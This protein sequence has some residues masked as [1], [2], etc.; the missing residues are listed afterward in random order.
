MATA[1][2][3]IALMPKAQTGLRPMAPSPLPLLPVVPLVLLPPGTAVGTKGGSV[4]E[5]WDKSV[6]VPVGIWTSKG[7]SGSTVESGLP[8]GVAV[9]AT[10]LS[11]AP[12]ASQ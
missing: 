7:E 4:A 12:D 1:M 5:N 10:D 8:V 3:T 9:I 2:A 11:R 6:P